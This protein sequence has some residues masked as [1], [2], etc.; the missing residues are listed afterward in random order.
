[1]Y[2]TGKVR[3][4]CNKTKM[5]RDAGMKS[6]SQHPNSRLGNVRD[7]RRYPHKMVD[8]GR[9][10]GED[11]Y[12]PERVAGKVANGIRFDVGSGFPRRHH[13]PQVMER[14][15]DTQSNHPWT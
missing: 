8:A 9:N 14:Q 2:L 15:F 12:L 6:E 4:F 1:M 3:V 10:G 7:A 5:A 11:P 13:D